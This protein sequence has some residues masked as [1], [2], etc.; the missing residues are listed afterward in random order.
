MALSSVFSLA[1]TNEAEIATSHTL[2]HGNAASAWPIREHKST[3]TVDEASGPL[4]TH[5]IGVPQ[6]GEQGC[7]SDQK[8]H[9][10]DRTR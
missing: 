3:K 5:E 2:P 10:A 1:L 4:R 8:R 6:L 9:A 7:L